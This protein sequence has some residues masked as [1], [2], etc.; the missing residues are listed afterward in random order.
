MSNSSLVSYTKWSPNHS[1]A[2]NQKIDIITIHM[3]V[4]QAAVETL[5]E[6]FA[7][8]NRQASS[9]YGVGYDGRIGQYVDE[10]NRSWCSSSSWNDNRAITIETASDNYAPYAVNWVAYLALVDL[11]ADICKRNGK[12]KMVW[13]PTWDEFEVQFGGHYDSQTMYMT[14][15]RWFA[16]TNCPGEW[17][18]VRMGDIAD[19]VNA[20][21][22]PEEKKEEE[23]KEEVK[24]V[25]DPFSDVAD[26]DKTI[27]WAYEQGIVKG[28]PDGTF[29]PD[30][31]CT[32]RQICTMLYRYA[33]SEENKK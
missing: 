32:R 25:K 2:R 27:L 14:L 24:P 8:P 18:E 16:S 5:G 4:G 11:C 20:I 28:Y 10:A 30:E 9:N 19:R 29:R 7:N 22:T 26:S 6:V 15:H 31:P 21:L 1:G 3:V 17:L 23:K 12:T 33:K 13:Y